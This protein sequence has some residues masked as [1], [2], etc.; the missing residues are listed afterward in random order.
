MSTQKNITEAHRNHYDENFLIKP[1]QRKIIYK[2]LL[3]LLVIIKKFT[4][5]LTRTRQITLLKT[6]PKVEV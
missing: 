3:K 1:S 6:I 4:T 2:K 5:I